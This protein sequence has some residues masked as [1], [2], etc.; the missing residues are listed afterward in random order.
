MNTSLCTHE[1]EDGSYVLQ[2]IFLVVHKLECEAYK[3]E[4]C[5]TLTD[6]WHIIQD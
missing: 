2:V 3:G 1:L 4:E 6:K 5:H